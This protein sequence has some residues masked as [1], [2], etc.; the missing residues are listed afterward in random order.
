MESRYVNT[1]PPHRK[2]YTLSVEQTLFGPA[3]VRRWGRIGAPGTIRAD[4]YR[5]PEDAAAA[6]TKQCVRRVKR[7]YSVEDAEYRVANSAARIYAS[8]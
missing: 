7:G 2:W 3:V 5:T 6:Y 8:T 4:I 1:K